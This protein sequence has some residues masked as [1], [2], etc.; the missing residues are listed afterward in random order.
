MLG[1]YGNRQII[2][3]NLD[4]LASQG[5]RF[6]H[7]IAN[8]PLC[9]PFRGLLL[10]GQHP[11]RTGAFE[12]DFR[13]LAGDGGNYFGE[14]LRDSGYRTGYVGKWHLYGGDRVRPIPAGPY[15]YGFDHRFLSNNCTVVFD[16]ERAYYWTEDGKRKL[17]GDWEPYAQARQAMHFID[18]N[19]DQPFA[20]FLS[21]HPP[22]N[23]AGQTKGPRA[24]EDGHQ[25]PEDL[26][27][28]YDP[29]SIQLRGNCTDTPSARNLY[30]GYMA[31]CTS[32]DRAFG[33]LMEQLEKKGL[34]DNT[35]VVFT[36]DHG[37]TALS[38]GLL[39]N[40]MRPEIESIRVP[41]IIRYPKVLQPRASDLLIGGIDLMS[42]LLGMMG[43]EIPASCQGQNLTAA[44]TKA[45]DNEVESIPLFYSRW[46]G[47]G[48]T[49][50]ATRTASILATADGF[51]IVTSCS[52]GRPVCVGTVYMRPIAGNRPIYSM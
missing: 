50:A 18:E 12:N 25:A 39:A 19:A 44:I 47:G 37:D 3:P 48:F 7:C 38:H 2:T 30:R 23:W 4:R 27:A 8:S 51:G 14:V 11:L 22:H 13:M 31:M 26:T 35:I 29:Q 1:C 40:K 21:W 45:R 16:A 36:S 52:P 42:T 20:L 33:W 15:R 46:T 5:V 28:L 34:A 32:V 6:N 24:P 10:S 49:R 41:L 43:L 17:Y 9:T